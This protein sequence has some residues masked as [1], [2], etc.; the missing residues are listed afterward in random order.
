MFD[1]FREIDVEDPILW[2]QRIPLGTTGGQSIYYLGTGTCTD[3]LYSCS[4]GGFMIQS[5]KGLPFIVMSASPTLYT[6]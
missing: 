2:P 3:S 5:H 4:T 6:P 1:G